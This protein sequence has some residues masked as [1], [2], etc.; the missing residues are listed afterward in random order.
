MKK[1][2]LFGILIF[3]ISFFSLQAQTPDEKI[4]SLVNNND[5]F[6]LDKQYRLLKDSIHPMLKSFS[7]VM[8]NFAFNNPEKT[9][10]YADSLVEK[11]QQEIGFGNVVS[12]I[13]IKS[14]SL[15]EMEEY[16]RAAD[17]IKE[18][19]HAASTHM[20]STNIAM[21]NATYEYYNK[22]RAIP[23][24]ELIRP[25]TDS[26]IPI[27]IDTL[28]VGGNMMYIPVTVNGQKERFIL[29]TGCPTAAFFSERLA[30]KYNIKTIF[31]S[32]KVQGTGTGYGRLGFLDSIQVGDMTLKNL[33]VTVV[34]SNPAVDSVFQV[35]AILG[36]TIMKAAKEMQ[37]YPRQK[38]VVFPI[39]QTL[40]PSTDRNMMMHASHPF[41][42]AFHNGERLIMHFDTGN[43]SSN[44][45]YKFY[46]KHKGEIEKNGTK[47]S[48]LGGGF[49]SVIMKELYSLPSFDLKV[50]N[51]DFTLKKLDVSIEPVF[52]SQGSEE[53][54]LGMSFIKLF[55]KVTINFDHM[56]VEVE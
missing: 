18:F 56:F 41:I 9:C 38:K 37:I 32:L 21:L 6:E 13:M 33:L 24:S 1:L 52:V 35:D 43:A 8:L 50:G 45:H 34:P 5:Y 19:L 20:D 17:H 51:T 25:K 29:D 27:E 31:D 10:T 54:S 44:L 48:R 4:G 42:K 53:G 2:R 12:M 49:G 46:E 7:E 3:S 36:Q 15:A 26:E 11:H 55:D 40:M 14:Q 16:G 28:K 23:K 47:Y 39:N 22:L 30:Q